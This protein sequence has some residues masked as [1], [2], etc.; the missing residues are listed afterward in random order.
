MGRVDNRE[1][2]IN[3]TWKDFYKEALELYFKVKNKDMTEEQVQK[4]KALLDKIKCLENDISEIS[5]TTYIYNIEFRYKSNM[6]DTSCYLNFN[7]KDYI[8]S[9][10]IKAILLSSLN[11]ELERCQKELNCL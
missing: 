8:D 10:A 6:F 2:L 11:K 7:K 5:K 9:K 4:G 3:Y 1:D